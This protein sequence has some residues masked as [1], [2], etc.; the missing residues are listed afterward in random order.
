MENLKIVTFQDDEKKLEIYVSKDTNEAWLSIEQIAILF[1]K[2]RATIYNYISIT[3]KKYNIGEEHK[4]LNFRQIVTHDGKNKTKHYTLSFVIKLGNLLHS[5][6]AIILK[7]WLNKQFLTD[8]N[9]KEIIVYNNGAIS[10][11]VTVSPLEETVW[12][13]QSLIAA[14]FETSQQNI[15]YH[16]NNIFNEGELDTSLVHKEILY[17]GSDNKQYM[18]DFYNL[19]L[20]LAVGY[21]VKS[22]RAIEFRKW[23][24][25]V[26]KQYLL[27]GYSIDQNRVQVTQENVLR[28][29]NDVAKIKEDI[30]NIKSQISE[31]KEIIFKNGRYYDAFEYISKIMQQAKTSVIIIDP[32][33]DRSSLIYL[34]WI[35]PKINKKIYFENIDKIDCQEM[36]MLRKQ[37]YPLNF[38]KINKIHDRF[39]IIDKITCYGIGT[40]LNHA[41][42][43]VFT[44]NKFETESIIDT[45]LQIVSKKKPI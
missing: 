17:T 7:D 21:R 4:C 6:Q 31:P 35:D 19:D 11:D 28:L 1:S 9:S 24:T 38:Y 23:V 13:T 30:T 2:S 8:G 27:K 33:F 32:Y 20:I 29:E 14:L 43:K 41:G 22:K 16:I 39:I 40:S 34:K 5:N 37:Y 3:Y 12:L 45:L 10:I 18:H 36:E 15:S 44:I 25:N 26:L 42:N